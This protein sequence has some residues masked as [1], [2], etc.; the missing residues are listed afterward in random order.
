MGEVAYYGLSGIAAGMYIWMLAAGLTIAFGVLRIL[1]FAHGALYM[2]GGFFALTFY[3][4][5]GLNFGLSILLAAITVGVIGLGLE[6]FLIRRVY[7]D[8]LEIQL[9]LT[10]AFV[11]IF[12][13][14]SRYVWG[15]AFTVARMPALLE[16]T[17]LIGGT[18][19]SVYNLA[20][21][22]I[23]AAVF[24]AISLILNKTWWGRTMRAT[25]SDRNM[26]S[27]VGINVGNVYSTTFMF[28]SAVAAIGGALSI[29]MRCITAGTG[30]QVIIP[31]FV[32]LVVGTLGNLTGAFV[33]AMIIGLVQVYAMQYTAWM[34]VFAMYV[35]MA[36]VLIVRPQGLFG[37][38][39]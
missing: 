8:P 27:A 6:R 22:G 34:G 23:G 1:N 2:F 35:V 15:T 10:F 31:A 29:P 20:L 11:L 17:V 24:A 30:T 39:R 12:D 9:I 18:T 4:Q 16:G 36:I 3:H 26:A 32:V 25:A 21:I 38:A 14:L 19:F 5:M 37:R 7:D 28:A 13:N 33:A